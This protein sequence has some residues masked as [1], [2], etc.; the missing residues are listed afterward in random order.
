MLGLGAP[1]LL[2]LVAVREWGDSQAGADADDL[3][4]QRPPKRF[5]HA[6]GRQ[7]VE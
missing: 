1:P 4:K 2:P 3:Q 5:E 7:V 6:D